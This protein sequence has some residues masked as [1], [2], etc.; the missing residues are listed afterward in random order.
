MKITVATADGA[1]E[2]SASDTPNFIV[3]PATAGSV[4]AVQNFGEPSTLYQAYQRG[5]L[6][7]CAA[8]V[9]GQGVGPL[10]LLRLATSTA[11]SLPAYTVAASAALPAN[12][13]APG[14]FTALSF[15]GP[16][17]IEVVFGAGWDGGNVT[18]TGTDANGAAQ[19]ETITAAP[20][21]AVKGN[22]VFGT[23]TGAVKASVGATAN[24]ATLQRGNKT[25][26]GTSTS[27]S[28]LVLSGTPNDDGRV[29][30]SVTR[31]G[32]PAAT[33]L[34]AYSVSYDGGDTF[35]PETAVPTGG[36]IT[37]DNGLTA[38]LSGSA[39]KAGDAFTQDASGPT[40]TSLDV[41]AALAVLST[42]NVDGGELLI[43]G[44]VSGAITA[45]V[46]SWIAS[47]RAASRDWQVYLHTRDY[48]SASET[49]SAY[50]ASLQTDF[51]GLQ[52]PVGALSVIPGYWETVIPGGRGIQRRSFAW[53]VC[54]Q[55]W[56][57]PFYVH[58]SCQEDGGG[59]LRGLHTVA[60][61]GTPRTHDER[62]S[63][64]LGGSGGRFLT[65]QSL[66]GSENLGQWFVG[67]YA[68]KRSPGTLAPGTSDWSL[69]M[70]ARLAN[71]TRRFVQ[72]YG[73]RLLAA[74]YATLANG[75]LTSAERKRV[76]SKVSKALKRYLG[77]A[78]QDLRVVVSATE[79]I[80]TSK[81]LPY[82]VFLRSWSYALE[83]V[84]IIGLQGAE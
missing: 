72:S 11:G 5:K 4:S 53:A 80:L 26:A 74:R 33:P 50:V 15:T 58:P 30:F 81:K 55:L 40:S 1:L 61:A 54:A 39:C 52:E 83:V 66:P 57:L 24:T 35:G 59:A 6:P 47:E 63:P 10:S 36:V 32:D 73:A 56:R 18:L 77:P 43:L 62:T 84:S 34:P 2:Y 51:A 41:S 3:G 25:A 8:L 49:D 64:G 23:L 70:N 68:G 9:F 17:N 76:E 37:L 7:D 65:V 44:G 78:V 22:K 45:V 71:R 82:Q 75:T 21:S 60:A 42:L 48:S 12:T 19:T 20:G 27:T 79:P 38:T 28:Q 16:A 46:N 13:A 29:V 14:A 31:D 69:L 67:D